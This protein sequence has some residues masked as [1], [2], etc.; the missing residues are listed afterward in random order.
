MPRFR[1][2]RSQLLCVLLLGLG[3]SLGVFILVVRQTSQAKAVQEIRGDFDHAAQIFQ[4]RF[5]D[6]LQARSQNAR[7]VSAAW[8]FRQMFLKTT[9]PET[10]RSAL[11]SA[12]VRCHANTMALVDDDGKTLVDLRNSIPPGAPSPYQPLIQQ[13]DANGLEYAS[14]HAY[15]GDKLY[16]LVV[17]PISVDHVDWFGLANRIDQKVAQDL[18]QLSRV[19]VAF[20]NG[21]HNFVITTLPPETK[22]ALLVQFGHDQTPESEMTRQREI[23]GVPYFTQQSAIEGIDGSHTTMVLAYSLDEKLAPTRELQKKLLEIGLLFLAV[24]A[25]LGIRVARDVSEPVRRLAAHT[26]VIARPDY[27]TK[28]QLDR[29]DEL[30]QLAT[31]LNRMSDRLAEAE[32]DR[33]LVNKGLSPQVAAE[34]RHHGELGGVLREVTILFA[35][36]RGFTTLSERLTPDQLLRLLNRCFERLVP[37]IEKR[38]GIVDK[39]VGDEIMALFGTPQPLPDAADQALRA[40]LGMRQ[41]LA[42]LNL[43]LAANGQPAIACSI[44]LNT[45]HVI[46][47]NIGTAARLNYTVIGDGVNLAK[48]IESA[49]RDL[50]ADL[51]VS[52]STLRA[53]HDRYA[54]RDLGEITVKGRSAPV[55]VFALDHL[56]AG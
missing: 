44:G 12:V 39:F 49:T 55:R 35:D 51:L 40:A 48:R 4:R 1:H 21:P 50:G 36:L 3:A 38:G 11:E 2:F 16:A 20:I 45:A 34:M 6:E 18:K 37:E 56:A 28:I 15:F 10:L 41:A 9:D 19:D 32:L 31:A 8:E 29:G 23:L 14:G 7:I 33:D 13:A 22:P 27:K 42:A 25:L 26:E 5:D 54:T 46:A 24:G 47:G 52:E 43:E 30:G 53:A 17:V